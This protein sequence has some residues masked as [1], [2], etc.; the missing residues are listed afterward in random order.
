[1]THRLSL[2]VLLAVSFTAL[3]D[4]PA[5]TSATDWPQFHGPKRDNISTEKGLLQEWPKDGPKLLWKV[6]GT[7]GGFSS[8]SISGGKIFTAGEMGNESFVIAL[9]ASDGKQL[10]KAPLGKAGGGQGHP[11]P[12]A[13]PTVDGDR[14]YTIGQF[15]D[16]VANSIA[17]GKELW[18][19]NLNKDHGGK[20][21]SGW[22]NSESLLVDG[23]NL[24]CTPGGRGGTLMALDK[25]TGKPVWR[26]KEFGDDAAYASP[27]VVEIGGVRQ[28]PVLTDKNVAGINVA[29]GSLLWRANRPGSTAVISIPVVHEN[30]VYVTSAYGVGCDLFKINASGGKFTAEPV[31][32]KNKAMVNHHGGVIYLDGAL[33]GYSD[34]KG[35]TCQDFLS[36]EARWKEK[37]A[38][39]K[40][41]ISYA[42]GRFYLRDEKKGTIVLIEASKEAWKEKGRFEQPDR[43]GKNAWPHLVIAGGKL[44]VRDQDLLLCYDVKAK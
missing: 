18:R 37:D 36:G 32:T 6:K 21:M 15:G 11:G 30:Y 29:D 38:L 44:Y 24:I 28:V 1:M 39:G 31:Y 41:T 12:R 34:G 7:G 4:V 20:M 8:V 16:I 19:T 33:Y 13:T 22:G 27:F 26:S 42:D 10:W 14:L 9:S 3:A 43:S 40:G 5:K 25:M 2:I 17:D 35:W 23:N